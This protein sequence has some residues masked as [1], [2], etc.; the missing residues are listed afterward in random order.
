MD[1]CRSAFATTN[2]DMQKLFDNFLR[3]LDSYISLGT[4]MT[5]FLIVL[6]Q[7]NMSSSDSQGYIYATNAIWDDIR[8]ELMHERF[9]TTNKDM[10]KMFNNFLRTLDSFHPEISLGDFTVI[11]RALFISLGTMMTTYLIVLLQFNMS[12]SDSHGYNIT[13]QI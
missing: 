1:C 7:F 11:N 2:K 8:D 9:A 10:Q 6:L 12:S 4:M 3:T 5:T 13:L